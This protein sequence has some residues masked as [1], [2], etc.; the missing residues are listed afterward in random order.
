MTMVCSDYFAFMCYRRQ[1]HSGMG[2]TLNFH[3]ITKLDK[4]L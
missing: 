2:D 4:E 3:R 1:M